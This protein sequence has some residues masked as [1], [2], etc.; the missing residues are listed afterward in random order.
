MRSPRRT[1]PC[2][3]T[4]WTSCA[5]SS[6]SSRPGSAWKASPRSTR[7]RSSRR[8]ASAGPRAPASSRRRRGRAARDHSG[9]LRRALPRAGC[10]SARLAR[11]RATAAPFP[12]LARELTATYD[13]RRAQRRRLRDHHRRGV[14]Q[15]GRVHRR[16]DEHRASR[17]RRRGRR[18]HHFSGEHDNGG[19]KVAEASLNDFP[20][21]QIEKTFEFCGDVSII[22]ASALYAVADGIKL[23]RRC[24]L[25][26]PRLYLALH[27]LLV[28]CR[29]VIADK[30]GKVTISSLYAY[31]TI[32]SLDL[33]TLNCYNS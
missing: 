4:R 21:S 27:A 17:R 23:S 22:V 1:R 13:R 28:E 9:R 16:A 12:G 32:P 33:N 19:Q 15:P 18:P 8:C 24:V 30:R 26:D 11:S 7:L 20:S 6:A 3:A 5:P 29:Q 10:G 2:G 14:L 25:G 31:F